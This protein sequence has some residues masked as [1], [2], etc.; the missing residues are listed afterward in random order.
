MAFERASACTIMAA[1]TA[2]A[3]T[4]PPMIL[5]TLGATEAALRAF[6]VPHGGGLDAAAQ[7]IATELARRTG[8]ASI[9]AQ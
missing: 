3:G 5:G 4:S 8:R 2:P 6:E 9:A 1:S 7:V